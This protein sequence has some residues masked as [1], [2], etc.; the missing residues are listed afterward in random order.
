MTEIRRKAIT[1]RKCVCIICFNCFGNKD[2]VFK[3]SVFC[4]HVLSV[5]IGVEDD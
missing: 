2:A 1:N 5:R 4:M 3:D